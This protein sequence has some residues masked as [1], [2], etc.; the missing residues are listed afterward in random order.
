[1]ARLDKAFARYYWIAAVVG[2]LCFV[3]NLTLNTGLGRLVAL[4]WVVIVPLWIR[5][6]LQWR[7][8]GV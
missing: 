4:F 3:A 1:M 2:T 6:Y 8:T 7:R 5:R